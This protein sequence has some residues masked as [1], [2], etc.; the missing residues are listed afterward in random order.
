MFNKIFSSLKSLGF[1]NVDNVELYARE[2]K[3][4]KDIK[5]KEVKV[6]IKDLLYDKKVKCPV[7]KQEI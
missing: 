2:E 7:C 1:N 4:V 3:K 6:E 5:A